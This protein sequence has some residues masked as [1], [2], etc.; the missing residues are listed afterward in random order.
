MVPFVILGTMKNEKCVL[1]VTKEF[2]LEIS[3]A[4]M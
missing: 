4:K 1:T 3:T 2:V